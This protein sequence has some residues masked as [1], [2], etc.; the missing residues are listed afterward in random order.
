MFS[1]DIFIKKL[2]ETKEKKQKFQ[3]I[4][5]GIMFGIVLLF[6]SIFRLITDMNINN[7]KFYFILLFIGLVDLFF[8][9]FI[10]SKLKYIEKVVLFV[11]KMIGTIILSILLLIVYI[12]WFIP[13]SII[14]KF[15]NKKNKTTFH[16]KNKII[17]KKSSNNIFSQING[18][19]SYFL[20]DGGWYLIPI[21]LIFI[22]IGLILFFAQ[23]PAVAPL[24]YPLI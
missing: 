1:T 24:I 7:D 15:L 23:S 16:S 2:N 9:I 22:I 19:F 18:I 14:S 13:A 21:L 11:G 17:I 12:I 3:S 20:F 10:P 6:V 4:Y 5:F 8:V